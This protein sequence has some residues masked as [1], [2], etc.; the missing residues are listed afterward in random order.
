M[1]SYHVALPLSQHTNACCSDL[2]LAALRILLSRSGGQRKE[3]DAYHTLYKQVYEAALGC[4][5][6]SARQL[7]RGSAT[8]IVY[9]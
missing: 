9:F 1:V 7:A 5:G 2:T 3:S 6:M 8:S 4:H